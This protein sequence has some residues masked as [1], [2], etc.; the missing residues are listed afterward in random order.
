M[1]NE[2][3]KIPTWFW[4]V[5]IILLIWNLMG[6]LNFFM[7]I[8][9]TDE[10]IQAKPEREQEMYQNFP[11]WANAAFGVAVF[12]G[13]AGSIAL[14]MKKRIAKTLFIISLIGVLVQMSWNL[15]IAKAWEINTAMVVGLSVAILVVGILSI[16]LSKHGTSKSWLT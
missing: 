14:L 13:V 8:T 16:W 6:V 9:M 10:I 11:W 3:I 7:Q 12:G 1:T 15:L 4:V 5:A 2:P